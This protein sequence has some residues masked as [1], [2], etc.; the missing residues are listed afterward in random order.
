M[1]EKVVRA[2]EEVA[3]KYKTKSRASKERIL[4]FNEELNKR[5]Y[6]S[7]IRV[8]KGDDILAACGQL[9]SNLEKPNVWA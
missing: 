5:G 7:T 2:S 4:W 1:A 9:K 8:T 3:L 6:T